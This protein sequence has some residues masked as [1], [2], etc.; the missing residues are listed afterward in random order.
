MRAATP[1]DDPA[2]QVTVW[3]AAGA[4]N[5]CI[6]PA[7]PGGILQLLPGVRNTLGALLGRPLTVCLAAR[8]G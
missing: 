7:G 1:C 6:V 2:Q 8:L 5:Q 3:P 4:A